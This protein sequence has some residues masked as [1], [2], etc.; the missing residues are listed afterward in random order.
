MKK[1]LRESAYNKL[2]GVLRR[3]KRPEKHE[4]AAVASSPEA[5]PPVVDDFP[6]R[7]A[8]F[9]FGVLTLIIL[10]YSYLI[11]KPFLVEIFLALVLFIVSKP[12]YSGILRLLRGQRGLSSALTCLLLALFIIAPLLTLASLIAGQALDIYNLI[13]EGLHSGALWQDLTDKMAF[14]QNFANKYNLPVSVDKFQLEQI[15]RSALVT[16]SQFVYNNAIGLV[17]GFTGV[18]FSLLLILF[19]TFFCFLQG[20]DFINAIKEL[21]PL[22]PAHNEEILGDVEKTIKATLRGTVIVALIQGVLGGIGFFIFGVPKAAFWGTLMIPASVIPVVGAALIWFPGALFLFFQGHTWHAL[23]LVFWGVV[24]I[25]S[26]DNLVKPYLMKGARYT[27]VVFILFAIMG[28]IAYFG[29]VGFILGPL[30]LSFLLSVLS[31]YQK[32]IL[33]QNRSA[34]TDAARQDNEGNPISP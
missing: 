13:N 24:V 27:P 1:S 10:Y 19:I 15:I 29:T 21:S 6:S 3:S 2:R 7:F 34:Q 14:V 17:K 20:D 16:A 22:D 12:L 11:I 26:I 9:F 31:I 25:G 28:G 30:I 23:G 8:R 5:P 33:R 18:I 32:T 4:A